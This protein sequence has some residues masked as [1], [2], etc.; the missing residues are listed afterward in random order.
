MLTPVMVS[1]IYG[2]MQKTWQAEREMAPGELAAAIERYRL[3]QADVG[4]WLGVTERTVRRYLRGTAVIPV[5]IVLLL[6]AL[7]AMQVEPDVP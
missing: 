4:A 5:P 3:T 7:E 1:G 2:A 6:R